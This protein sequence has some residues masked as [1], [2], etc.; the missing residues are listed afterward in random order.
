MEVESAVAESVR[1]TKDGM[2]YDAA[3]KRV[4]SNK[5]ILAHIMKACV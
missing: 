1:V 3:C 5:V 2:K 4:L